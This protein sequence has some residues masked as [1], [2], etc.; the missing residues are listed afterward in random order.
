VFII[1]LLF[2]G[3]LWNIVAIFCC[4]GKYETTEC[5]V[6][7]SAGETIDRDEYGN[8]ILCCNMCSPQNW[9]Y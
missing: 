5:R 7:Q 4:F 8:P 9:K 3:I 6:T 1:Y 2:S